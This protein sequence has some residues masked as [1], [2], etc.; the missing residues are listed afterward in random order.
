MRSLAALLPLLIACIGDPPAARLTPEQQRELQRYVTSTPPS[1]L[2]RHEGTFAGVELLG[3]RLSPAR[4]THLA[5]TTITI[6]L[7]WRCSEPLPHGYRLFSHLLDA[8]GRMLGNL[9]SQGPLRALAGVTGVPLPPSAWHAGLVYRDE[10]RV[11]LPPDAPDQVVIAAGFYRASERLVASGKG[12]DPKQRAAIIK[13]RVEGGAARASRIPE[14][15]I[16][17]LADVPGQAPITID[18]R[19]DEAAWRQA[20]TTG[21][22]VNPTTGDPDPGGAVQGSARVLWNDQA[23]YVGFEVRDTKVRGG[24]PVDAVDPHLWTRDT[25]ELMIDP[26][27]DGD[28]RDY[29]EIQV[30]PQN[31]VF[32]SHFDAYNEPRGGSSGPFG[33]QDWR[34]QVESAVRIQGTLDDDSDE[35]VGY[36]VEA[37]IPFKSFHKADRTPPRAGDRWR[38]NFYAMQDNGGVAW[39]PILGQGNFHRATRFGR[40]VFGSR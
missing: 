40:V 24:F 21:P 19:L 39:S 1:D 36:T 30:G 20:A 10:V 37:R 16:P 18:G 15:R 2:I 9:D 32:D 33:H 31:L 13:L 14:L 29:Y 22:F 28:N 6:T 23:L 3:Y 11:A 4:L 34:A 12:V 38:M 17:R 8:H 27:G 7:W 25:V 35:D 26:D 5:G